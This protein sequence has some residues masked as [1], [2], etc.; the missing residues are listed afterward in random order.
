MA[1]ILLP[2]PYIERQ[3]YEAFRQ[4]LKDQIPS[5]YEEWFQRF[6][7]T[8]EE[9]GPIGGGEIVVVNVEPNEF[10][11]FCLSENI[12]YDTNSL[13]KFAEKK[14]GTKIIR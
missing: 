8:R 2:L 3:D 10:R 9:G 14:G 12:P 4:I 13:S 11:S 1:K 7:R 5:T 6:S